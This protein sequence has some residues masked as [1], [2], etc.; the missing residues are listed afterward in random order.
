MATTTITASNDGIITSQD[1][2]YLLTQSGTGA[3]FVASESGILTV[4]NNYASGTG[5]YT[6]QHTYLKFATDSIPNTASIVSATLAIYVSTDGSDYDFNINAYNINWNTPLS[7]ISWLPPTSLNA[8]P[9][10]A[11]LDTSGISAPGYNNFT[12]NLASSINT[13]GDT[14]IVL[15][16]SRFAAGTT[17][18]GTY[19]YINAFSRESGAGYE[20]K[21]TIIYTENPFSLC[22]NF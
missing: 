4:N 2:S 14:N 11:T 15:A 8:F 10:G 7:T 13:G 21:L 12:G 22:E 18:D 6:A 16:S 17:P 9:V 1:S 19:E 3:Y 20:P 5:K